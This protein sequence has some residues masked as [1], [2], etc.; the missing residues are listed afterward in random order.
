MKELV[1]YS[2]IWCGPCKM[3]KPVLH[4]LK[5]EENYNITIIDVDEF[6]DLAREQSVMAVPTLVFKNDG[7]EYFRTI[8]YQTEVKIKQHYNKE[9]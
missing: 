7:V 9:V 8:G 5:E 6:S 2:A 1:V 4:K 3:L